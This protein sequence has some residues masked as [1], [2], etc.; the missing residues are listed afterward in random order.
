MNRE[1]DGRCAICGMSS[2]ENGKG[3]AVDHNH[4]TGKIRKLLCNNCN[5]A[6]GFVGDDPVLATKIAEY[7]GREKEG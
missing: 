6:V 7:L 1:Q 5:V 3:L 4:I 2:K